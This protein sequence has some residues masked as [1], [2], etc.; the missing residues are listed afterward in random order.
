MILIW[1]ESNVSTPIKH[2]VKKYLS[3]ILIY[4]TLVVHQEFFGKSSLWTL[5]NQDN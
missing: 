5:Q 1:S 2:L 4:Q 3:S